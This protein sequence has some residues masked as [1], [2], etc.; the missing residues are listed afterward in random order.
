MTN[1]SASFPSLQRQEKDTGPREGKAGARRA[2]PLLLRF[3]VFLEM[4]KFEHSIFALPFAYLGLLLAEEGMPRP[5]LF[6]YVTLAMV[7]FRTMGMALN[8]LV[9]RQIDGR[10]PRTRNRALPA[11]KLE[12]GFVWAVTLFSFFIFEAAAYRLGPLCFFLTPIPVFLAV[13]YPFTKRFTWISHGVLGI[14]LGIA[15]YGAWLASRGNFSWIPGLL[16]LGVACWAAGFDMIYALQDMDFD[17]ASALYSVPAR[18]GAEAALRLV[19][20]LHTAAIAAFSL[21]GILAGRGFFYFLGI[22]LSAVF[23]VREHRLLGSFGLKKIEEA[24]FSMNAAVGI[25]VFLGA[26]ADF[27]LGR[28]FS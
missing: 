25:T 8:R 15:P 27:S 5:S 7:S 18:F 26:A 1:K 21:S 12:P 22:G 24:F 19:R 17:R 16:T 3:A 11:K 9:D 28:F 2:V 14:I 10:N 20:F 4:I 6:F 23:L 13:L